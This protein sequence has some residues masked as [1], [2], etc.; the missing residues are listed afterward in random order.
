MCSSPEHPIYPY[1]HH[2]VKENSKK[3]DVSLVNS[4]SELDNGD[5][6][7]LISCT[8]IIKM[9][10]RKKFKHTLVIH[11][12]DLPKGRGWSP[13][14]WELLNGANVITI[15]LL[16]AVDKVDTG[17]IWK[18]ITINVNDYEIIDSI[19][20][21]LFP[22]K[23]SLINFAIQN[24]NLINPIKQNHNDVTYYARRTPK[25]NELDV[26]KTISE[27]FDLLRTADN[28]RY[29]SFFYFRNHKYKITLENFD[30]SE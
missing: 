23:I 12:S 17:D 4:S 27:Q 26:N 6:L 28:N 1:L 16:E 9:N 18:K 20:K 30:E 3:H 19:N 22:A 15:S 7:F 5:F 10:T 29:P 8:E 24:Y 21:K 2:W 13:L 14:I 11:E 25:D